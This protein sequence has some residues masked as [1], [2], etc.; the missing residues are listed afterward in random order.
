MQI[1]ASVSLGSNARK[2]GIWPAFWLMGDSV[3]HGTPWPQCGELDVF[4]QVN[5][6]MTAYGTIHCGTNPGG[7][8][9]EPNGKGGTVPLPDNGFHTWTARIDRTPADWTQETIS[10]FLDGKVFHTV[11]GAE[12]GDQAVWSTIA[13]SPLFI[14][15]NLAVGGDW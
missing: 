10:W 4:E 8:C 12:V 13:H 9:G 7:A 6:A 2:Q 3:H 1:E 14:I 15:M 11:A 5:G